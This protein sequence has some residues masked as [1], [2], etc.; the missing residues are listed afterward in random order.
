MGVKT[1]YHLLPAVQK[2]FKKPMLVDY[3]D[4]YITVW[5][6][7]S[8]MFS[9]SS[10]ANPEFIAVNQKIRGGAALGVRSMVLPRFGLFLEMGYSSVGYGSFGL[11]VVLN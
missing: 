3:V 10:H 4:P 8:L 7:Y 6:G 1:S 11:S 2:I 5:V 9:N